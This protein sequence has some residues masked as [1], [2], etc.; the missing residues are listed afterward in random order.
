MTERTEAP[1]REREELGRGIRLRS[2]F[3]SD[4][5]LR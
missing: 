2:L 4:R 5:E 3:S 1:R